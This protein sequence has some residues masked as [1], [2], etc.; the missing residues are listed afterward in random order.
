[1]ISRQD[2]ISTFKLVLGRTPEEAAIAGGMR[3]ENIP[4]LVSVI[5]QSVE[6]Q[7]LESAKEKS[8][9]AKERVQKHNSPTYS[10]PADLAVTV[11]AV[12]HVAFVGACFMESWIEPIKS[13]IKSTAIDY[14]LFNNAAK[15]PQLSEGQVRAY[16][17]QVIQVPLRSVLPETTY[18]ALP[19][20]DKASFLRL[21]E[22]SKL[23]LAQLLDAALAWN[24]EH[25][26]LTF[27]CNYM[28][29]QQNPMG[30]LLPRADLRNLS[31]MIRRLN[32]SLIDLISESNNVHLLDVDEQSAITG[33][34]YIQDDSVCLTTH[35]GMLNDWDH[36]FDQE[37]IH[38]VAPLSSNYDVRSGDFAL[39]LF[40]EL[41][42]MYR[43]I[44]S[45]DRIKLV[46]VDLD[47]TLWRGVAAEVGTSNVEGWPLGFIEA[48]TFLKKRG[49]L[50]SIVSKNSEGRVREIWDD[51]LGG[52]LSLDDFASVR[53][54][55]KSK[56]ENIGEILREV[57]VLPSSVLFI[58][59]NPVEI[60]SVAAVY[61]DI[62]TLGSDPHY[63]KRILLW[64]PETQVSSI[65][66]ES[67]RRTEMIQAQAEREASRVQ[68]SRGE[69]L[70]T[71]RLRVS[72]AHVVS[73]R[74]KRFPRALE[75]INKTN[76]FNTNGER[77]TA[78]MCEAHFRNDGSFFTM[79]VQDKYANYGLVGVII[80]RGDCLRQFV[81]SCRVFGL[82]V[83]VAAVVIVS[84]RLLEAGHET[85]RGFVT[86]TKSN[87][88]CRNVYQ[89]CGFE[90]DEFC[91]YAGLDSICQLP[92]HILAKIE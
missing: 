45:I 88:Q 56:S 42:A 44:Q 4:K 89:R 54:N 85:V 40:G 52:R 23:R 28:V 75:L 55:W 78:E 53:I 72:I 81:M 37:R 57:N 77:W 15:L 66:D 83:E 26:L 6:F 80:V 68:L 22:E 76:Q 7:K 92:A 79:D 48:L 90:N 33:K 25:G 86:E 2:V 91:W 14:Y 84:R 11:D 64:G 46:I 13:V 50:L 16:A 60:A 47:D 10:S 41:S 9:A 87:S 27:V 74:D 1:M 69:F 24:R 19:Y 61:P 20:D 8:T 30:R 38:P 63:L 58:D 67:V 39:Q 36:A 49:V 73:S 34:R 82:E 71:L 17:F 12:A 5:A 31:F 3:L 18:L 65:T 32:D 29:P 51:I 62:R 70:N 59:D 43:T 21:F 35:G